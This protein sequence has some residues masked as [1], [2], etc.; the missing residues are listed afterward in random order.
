[1][2]ILIFSEITLDQLP[3]KLLIILEVISVSVW[4]V[5]KQQIQCE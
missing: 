5:K 1:M 4:I 3:N 2:K